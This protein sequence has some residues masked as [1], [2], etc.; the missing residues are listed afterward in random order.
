MVSEFADD[1]EINASEFIGEDKLECPLCHN[2]S[3]FIYQDL[4][5]CYY[6]KKNNYFF[7]LNFKKT[8]RIICDLCNKIIKEEFY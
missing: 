8:T 2:K 6:N 1:I 4:E 3:I 7:F 5:Q